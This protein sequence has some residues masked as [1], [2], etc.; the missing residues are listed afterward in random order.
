MKISDDQKPS[1]YSARRANWQNPDVTDIGLA[2][3][4]PAPLSNPGAVANFARQCEAM[5]AASMWAVDRVAYDNIDPFAILATAAAVTDRIRLGTSVLLGNTR[6]P[7]HLAKSVASLDFL[8]NGRV[9]LG[10]GFGS[11]ADDYSAVELP[12][13]HRGTRAVEQVELMK[14]FWTEDN[15]T[16]HGRFYDVEDLSVGPRP[17]QEPHPPLWLG[18]KGE[19][20]L[21]RVGAWADGF[22][23][24]S[25]SIDSFDADWDRIC[26][27]AVDA[28]RDPGAITK[29]SL[30]FMAIDD[31]K[32]A[33]IQKVE[34]HSMRYYG[35]LRTPVEPVSVVGSPAQCVDRIGSFL[36]H[37]FGTFIIALADPDPRQLEL[38]GEKV[39]PQL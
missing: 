29:A 7:A 2:F 20:A 21:K 18:G 22:I 34:A 28:G 24:S 16:H 11:R 27:Y 26:G 25:T 12:F 15:V 13:E 36:S 10:L 1:L 31:D 19:P 37:D 5:G 39:F 38:F 32:E 3:V 8:S 30:S 17:I 4:N 33:A 35:R 14:R 9:T 6:H 23:S